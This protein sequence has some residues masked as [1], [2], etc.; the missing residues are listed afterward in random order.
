[1][2][3]DILQ[4]FAELAKRLNF[5]ETARLLNMSQATLS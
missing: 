3:T 5:T 1:M 2:D 4:E